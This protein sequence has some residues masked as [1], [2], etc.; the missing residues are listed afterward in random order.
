MFI[1]SDIIINLKLVRKIINK[2]N[3]KNAYI[4]YTIYLHVVYYRQVDFLRMPKSHANELKKT[5][6]L[7]IRTHLP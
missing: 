6:K 1:L 2:K 4:C 7:A 3:K 5:L